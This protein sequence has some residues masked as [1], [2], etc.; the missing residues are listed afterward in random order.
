[1]PDR[2]TPGPRPHSPGPTGPRLDAV[3]RLRR[4]LEALESRHPKRGRTTRARVSWDTTDS[5][6]DLGGESPATWSRAA[7]EPPADHELDGESPDSAP[8]DDAFTEDD[9][10]ATKPRRAHQRPPHGL[11]RSPGQRREE[12]PADPGDGDDVPG[13]DRHGF[14]D[15]PVTAAE[16][17]GSD[18]RAEAFA[19]RLLANGAR[20]R[21]ELADRVV[22]EGFTVETVDR[23]LN[24]LAAAGLIDGAAVSPGSGV[25]GGELH[26]KHAARR[27]S[28]AG[29]ADHV[30]PDNDRESAVEAEQTA[31]R[32][33]ETRGE[34]AARRRAERTERS[35]AARNAQF[36]D[37]ETG[38]TEAQAKEVCLRLLADRARSRSELADRLAAR[39]FTPEVANRA[40]DRL[41][42]V[43]LID[44]AAFAQQWVHS[45]HTYSGK[46]KKAL[47]QELRRKGVAQEDAEEAL[48]TITGDDEQVRATELVRRKLRSMPRELD[49]EKTI[50]RLVGM[51]ARRGYGSA[52]AYAVVKAE[53]D[54]AG[55]DFDSSELD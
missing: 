14:A 7:H 25:R 50:R 26:R 46:G 13:G 4:E 18:A 49:R 29:I 17:G 30:P 8:A 38:G 27:G 55:Q 22:A 47:A 20:S 43:G 51:L 28:E 45:R 2:E 52:T 24:R 15:V 41:T 5:T 48:S 40:L 10:P 16:D 3:E 6:W 21:A 54:N 53:L 44:D 31:F 19:I 12:V 32:A 39:G 36:G 34:R 1:M 11:R 42:E 9:H 33:R 37:P 23:A 35:R